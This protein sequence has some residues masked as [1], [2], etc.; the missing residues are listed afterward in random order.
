M[1]Q[2]QWQAVPFSNA[3]SAYGFVCPNMKL[4]MVSISKSTNSISD[5]LIFNCPMKISEILFMGFFYRTIV[6][7]LLLSVQSCLDLLNLTTSTPHK[8]AASPG[9]PKQLCVTQTNR[10]QQ[11]NNLRKYVFCVCCTFP[12]SEF[13]N[14]WIKQANYYLTGN[15]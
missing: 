11:I 10:L 13:Y 14:N 9:R 6:F 5:Y 4:C 12:C 8:R 15:F 3:V 7:I 2:S 1:C